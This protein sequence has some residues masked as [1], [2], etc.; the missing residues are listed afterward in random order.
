MTSGMGC[1]SGCADRQDRAGATNTA[2]AR[3]FGDDVEPLIAGAVYRAFAGDGDAVEVGGIKEGGHERPFGAFKAGINDGVLGGVK[4]CFE[5]GVFF[6]AEV[7]A[8]FEEDGP[9]HINAAV[10]GVRDD[11]GAA[12]GGGAG[13][14]GFLDG[15]GVE[16]LAIGDGAEVGDREVPAGGEEFREW[17]IEGGGNGGDAGSEGGGGGEDEQGR[18]NGV[19]HGE[20]LSGLLILRIM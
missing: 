1:G 20:P 8:F 4:P 10:I 16:G 12:A 15:S 7:G 11:D 18:K 13:V 3:A 14:N 5:N 9:G 17:E 19:A 6:Y 2:C